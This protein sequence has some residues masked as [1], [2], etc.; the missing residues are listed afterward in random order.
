MKMLKWVEAVCQS[1]ILGS[2]VE[3][4]VHSFSKSFNTTNFICNT[5]SVRGNVFNLFSVSIKFEFLML[6]TDNYR[7]LWY[8]SLNL[9]YTCPYFYIFEEPDVQGAAAQEVLD[10]VAWRR[11]H[12]DL[13]KCYKWI[14]YH[15]C[16]TSQKT[17][18]FR[19]LYICLLVEF[20][21][22]PRHEGFETGC[23]TGPSEVWVLYVT[24]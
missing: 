17:W 5:P 12:C 8:N 13:S 19:L 4:T 23:V 2:S 7:L 15:H 18:T 16:L 1:V 9:V 22:N 21:S 10:H 11:R 24:I 20:V 14:T 3:A 6:V